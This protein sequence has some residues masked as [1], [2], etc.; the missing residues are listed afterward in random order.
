MLYW[1]VLAIVLLTVAADCALRRAEQDLILQYEL[2]A[3]TSA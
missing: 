3:Q 2:E 1:L